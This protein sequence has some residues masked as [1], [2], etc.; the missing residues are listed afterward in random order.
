MDQKI[1]V[2]NVRVG[3]VLIMKDKLFVVRKTEHVKPGKGGAFI[4]MELKGLDS[5]TKLNERF[6]SEEN[7][8]KA[9]LEE[10]HAKFL[11]ADNDSCH[12]MFMDDTYDQFEIS[13]EDFKPVSN[14]LYD[15][16]EIKAMMHEE[17]VISFEFASP[18]VMEIIEADP[19]IKGQT[20]SSSY[21]NAVIENGIKI[22]VPTYIKQGDK[23]VVNPS[24][25]TYMERFKS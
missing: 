7:V 22:L 8:V 24:D 19:V 25:S 18:V 5:T 21:K 6:R 14:F 1:N 20:A 4:Q 16:V 17:K 9:I 15:G 12:F 13:K 10:K 3:N 23:I 2:S 11:Y